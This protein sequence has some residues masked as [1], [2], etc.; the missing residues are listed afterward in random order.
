MFSLKYIKF[1][2][3]NSIFLIIISFIFYLIFIERYKLYIY[4]YYRRIKIYEQ[5]F[6]I[7]VAIKSFYI[8][9]TIRTIWPW[10]MNSQQ[11]ILIKDNA[12]KNGKWAIQITSRVYKIQLYR[13]VRHSIICFA[14]N[15][16]CLLIYFF[17]YSFHKNKLNIYSDYNI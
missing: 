2:D 11:W 16:K 15:C 7:I 13:L 5:C 8:D 3:E 17:F 12:V 14:N 9:F 4:I 6:V 1:I 10:T